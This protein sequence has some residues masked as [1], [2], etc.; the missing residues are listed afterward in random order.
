MIIIKQVNDNL[1]KQSITRYILEALPGWFA[2]E[3][4][5][6]EAVKKEKEEIAIQIEEFL[7]WLKSELS[8]EQKFF[9]YIEER[10]KS[11][12]SFIEKIERN[13]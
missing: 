9:D 11:K 7:E 5:R 12:D 2:I 13:H 10:I 6:E 3:E 4:S 1:E 8:G